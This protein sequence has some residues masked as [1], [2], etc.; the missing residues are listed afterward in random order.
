MQRS[1][2]ERIYT[3]YFSYTQPMNNNLGRER[4]WNPEIW[5]AIDKAVKDEI[6]QIRVAQKVFP[7]TLMPGAVAVP[8]D[9]IDLENLR[10]TEGLTKPLIEISVEFSMS[11][12]QA[13]NEATLRTGRTLAKLAAKNVAMARTTQRHLA[14]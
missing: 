4:I 11:Q 9:S 6:G 1:H 7:A 13:D 12:A 10:I 14:S 8:D 3:L 5:T 2:G